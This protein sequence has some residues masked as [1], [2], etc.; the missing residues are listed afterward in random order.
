[1]ITLGSTTLDAAVI[2]ATELSY[3][4]GVTSAIQTQLNN[5]LPLSGGTVTGATTFTYPPT[6]TSGYLDL[7]S[8]GAAFTPSSSNPVIATAMVLPLLE[9]SKVQT[10]LRHLLPVVI[11]S[12]LVVLLGLVG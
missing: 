7:P 9:P 8:L 4:D 6:I 5:R 3:L 1:M 10:P 11:S 2:S 12:S